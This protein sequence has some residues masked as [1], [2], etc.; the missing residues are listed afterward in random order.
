MPEWPLFME[1][2]RLTPL[3]GWTLE[4]AVL[5]TLITGGIGSGKTTGPFQYVI[6]SFLLA[7]GVRAFAKGDHVLIE[8]EL[9]SSFY[10]KQIA[11]GVDTVTVPMTAWEIRA[12]AVRKLVRKQKPAA[13]AAKALKAAA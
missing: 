13:K 6:R 7:E 5:G 10:Q 3:D 1:L 11:V 12:H 2:L 8:G 9:R 4:Q